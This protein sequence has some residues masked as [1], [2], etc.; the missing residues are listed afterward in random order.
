MP[1]TALSRSYLC[2]EVQVIQAR[3]HESICVLQQPNPCQPPCH[4]ANLYGESTPPHAQARMSLR[5]TQGR[6]RTADEP[7]SADALFEMTRYA[8]SCPA[9]FASAAGVQ[10]ICQATIDATLARVRSHAC[11]RNCATPDPR[12]RTLSST[13]VAAPRLMSISAIM[14]WPNAAL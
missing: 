2:D 12:Q 10:P 7:A 9:A 4:A 11:K 3:L 5:S 6:C 8:S 13:V 14:G 1:C